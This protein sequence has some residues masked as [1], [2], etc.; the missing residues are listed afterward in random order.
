MDDCEPEFKVKLNE[1]RSLIEFYTPLVSRKESSRHSVLPL[2]K[3]YEKRQLICKLTPYLYCVCESGLVGTIDFWS[4]AASPGLHEEIQCIVD[5][6]GRYQWG[7][8][9]GRNT[10][11]LPDNY[12]LLHVDHAREYAKTLQGYQ[13]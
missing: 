8:W 5:T 2:F 11:A 4:L 3:F 13:H 7:L 6:A 9:D 12:L 10:I 1:I